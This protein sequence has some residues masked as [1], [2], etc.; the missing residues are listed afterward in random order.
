MDPEQLPYGQSP[1]FD[2]LPME[3]AACFL[4]RYRSLGKTSLTVQKSIIKLTRAAAALKSAG[5]IPR[6][7]SP[8][9]PTPLEDRDAETLSMDEIKELQKRALAF[10]V[11]SF[12]PE[13]DGTC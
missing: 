6:T 9:P 12:L 13:N 5:I 4:F 11:Y 7:P 1:F 2:T 3:E 8:P 10:K